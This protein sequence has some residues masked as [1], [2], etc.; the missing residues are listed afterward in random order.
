ML[1]GVNGS[2][3]EEP[4]VRVL[5]RFVL[6]TVVQVLVEGLN[7]RLVAVDPFGELALMDLN[8]GKPIEGASGK[9]NNGVPTNQMRAAP[10]GKLFFASNGY[11]ANDKLKIIDEAIAQ[12]RKALK[13]DPASA[14]L[15]ESLDDALNNKIQLL[16]TAA[17]LPSRM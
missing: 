14:Y 6:A 12:C 8:T 13:S 7:R 16:R 4:Y 1:S 11:G 9:F 3:T 5:P 15:M 17:A 2:S 10:D